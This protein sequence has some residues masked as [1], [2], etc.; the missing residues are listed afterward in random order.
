[1]AGYNQA[2]GY[3]DL[4]RNA[5]NTNY[6][7]A[8]APF[9]DITTQGK[10]GVGAYADATGANGQAGFDRAAANFRADPGY[11]FALDQGIQAIDRSSA[12]KTGG[13]LSGN[14]L[15]A[16]QQYGTGLADQSYGNYVSRLQPF[17]GYQTAGASGAAGVNMGLGNELNSSYGNQG[18][19]AFNTQVGIG[20]AEAAS[21]VARQNSAQNLVNGALNLGTKLLGF[22]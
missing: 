5:L 22:L 2:S 19:L 7:A 3:Y 1:M 11:K 12:A 9:S 10:A 15:T 20:N 16:L 18:N 4:G 13:A 6:A 21:D 14:L 8:L 17:L